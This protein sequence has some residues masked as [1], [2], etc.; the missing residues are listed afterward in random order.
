MFAGALPASQRFKIISFYEIR[1]SS[2]IKNLGV[3]RVWPSRAI[4]GFGAV[5]SRIDVADG[6]NGP[7][8]AWIFASFL[9]HKW[10]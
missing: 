6:Q 2:E 4:M 10:S 1:E 3:S 7:A 9:V 5:Q 8:F